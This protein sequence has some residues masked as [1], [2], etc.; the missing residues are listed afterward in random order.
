MRHFSFSAIALLLALYGTVSAQQRLV[1]H[2]D[3]DDPCR[4]FKMRILIPVD[5]V[6]HKLPGKRFARGFDSGMVWDPC[7]KVGPQIAFV[8]SIPGAARKDVVFPRLPFSFQRG[9]A[10]RQSKPEG[11]LLAPPRFTFPLKW[12]QP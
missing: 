12:Q 9:T 3:Q 4:R 7:P 5:V 10:E 8:P 6:D 2:N 1:R 11:F